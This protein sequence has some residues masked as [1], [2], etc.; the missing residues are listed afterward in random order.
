MG[1]QSCL[2]GSLVP[3]VFAHRIQISHSS[4]NHTA[5]SSSLSYGENKG[6][7]RAHFSHIFCYKRKANIF[8]FV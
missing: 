6:E 3:E 5:Y 7:I 1:L 2:L 4:L 8:Q